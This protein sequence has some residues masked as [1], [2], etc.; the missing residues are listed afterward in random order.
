MQS[1]SRLIRNFLSRPLD[2]CSNVLHYPIYH[3][4]KSCHTLS[5]Q[6]CWI[7]DCR[8]GSRYHVRQLLSD[9][10]REK[11]FHLVIAVLVYFYFIILSINKGIKIIKHFIYCTVFQC[12]WNWTRDWTRRNFCQYFCLRVVVISCMSLIVFQSKN[13]NWYIPFNTL[14]FLSTGIKGCRTCFVRSF[15]F[16]EISGNLPKCHWFISDHVLIQICVR[17]IFKVIVSKIQ[18]L[19]NLCLLVIITGINWSFLFENFFIYC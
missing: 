10:F 11:D 15:H 5:M 2:A 17:S 19:T 9:I 4:I 16:L 13:A 18:L 8:D 3:D 6:Y 7:Y 12:L 14:L 1:R